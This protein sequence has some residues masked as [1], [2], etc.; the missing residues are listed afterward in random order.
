M[1]KVPLTLDDFFLL[2]YVD[3]GALM[4][5][6]RNKAILGSNIIFEQMARMRLKMNVGTRSKAS[7]TESVYFP[8]LSKIT[9]WLLNHESL[10]ISSFRETFS[11]VEAGKKEKKS[12]VI[13]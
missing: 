11:F 1:N 7:K 5:S 8:S 13:D 4:F 10:Q 12:W 3:D 9:S 6:S 2:L